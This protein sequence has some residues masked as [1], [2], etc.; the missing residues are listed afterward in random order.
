MRTAPDAP[1]ARARILLTGGRAAATLDLARALWR[2]GHRVVLAESMAWHL[3][4]G[5]R[6][7]ARH[8]RVPGAALDP[9]GFVAG[10][11]RIVRAE[12]IDLVIPTCE[13]IFCMAAAK[14][15]L[16]RSCRVL[17]PPLEQLARLHDKAR[18]VQLVRSCGL[19]AP[20]TICVTSRRD[21]ELHLAKALQ[22][23][24]QVVLKPVFSRFAARVVV[25]PR[26]PQDLGQ[27]APT[28]DD[29]W[30]IQDF[31]A[32]RQICTFGIAQDGRLLAHAAYATR[33]TLGVGATVHFV[34]DL[35]PRVLGWV[36]Q[37]V[38]AQ[39]F[40]GQIA[41]DLIE[42]DQG[43]LWAIECNPRL[44]SGVHLL[45]HE[46]A[47]VDA[48]LGR[49]ESLLLAHAAAP[50]ML[51]I[52]MLL[53]LRQSART[54][55]EFARW[56]RDFWG[57]R[58]VARSWL[59]PLPMVWSRFAGLAGILLRARRLGISSQQA[60]TYDMEW[61]GGDF[62]PDVARAPAAPAALPHRASSADVH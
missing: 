13:E 20:D 45:V 15:R 29:P 16:E 12:R 23:G 30:L 27:V 14:E 7:I 36:Q 40:S 47:L 62:A 11:E 17:C 50:A 8:Y 26:G 42:D 3:S 54:R 35:D 58:D 31:V 25:R 49:Q 18:F 48:Y 56:W 24:R 19:L 4:R 38:A 32:G 22:A 41:F 6:A 2:A 9:A 51:G 59:D 46:K 55:Q 28:P 44:T 5:S 34:A 43:Q 39:G 33:Y 52:S 61:N 21:L 1:G 57:A 10:V 60:A 53:C 37:L